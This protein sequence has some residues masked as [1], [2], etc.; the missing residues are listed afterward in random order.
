MNAKNVLTGKLI[1]KTWHLLPT[2]CYATIFEISPSPSP[3][4]LRACVAALQSCAH[5]R[6]LYKGKEIHSWMLINGLVDSPFSVTSLINMYSKC[7]QLDDALIIFN[8]THDR[9]VYTWNAMMA[10]FIANGLSRNA[11]ELYQRMR[12]DGVVVPDK[13]TFPSAIKACSDLLEVLEVRKIHAGL[14]KFGLENDAFVSSALINFYLKIYLVE[15]AQL[16]FEE[17]PERDV[18]LWNAMINGYAQIGQFIMALQVFGMM[19]KENVV[20]SK[21]TVTGILSVLTMTGDLDNGRAVHGF[22]KKMGYESDIAVSNSLIDMYG[23]CKDVVDALEIFE[24]MLDRDIFSWNSIIAVHQQSGDHDGT[25]SL[26][27]RMREAGVCPDVVTITTVLPACSS[28]A[29]LMRGKEIHGYTIVSGMR[30]DEDGEEIHDIHAD[31]AILDM[32]AKCG[33]LKDAGLFFDK[34]R[35]KDVASWNIMIMGYGMHGFGNE[36]LI[37]F[38]LMCESGVRPDE[39]SFV[40]VLSACSH[41]GLV[42][43]G[44]QFLARMELDHGVI[45]TVEHYAC[46]VDMLGRAGRL[47]E[48]YKLAVTM[49]IESNPVVWRAF[50][51]ACRIHGNTTLAEIA[52]KRLLEIEPEH[53]GS[54]VLISNVYGSMGRYEDVSDVRHTMRQRNVKKTPGCSWIELKFGVHVFVTGDRMHPESDRIHAE[55]DALTGCLREYGYVPEVSYVQGCASL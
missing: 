3:C 31:N 18:V 14:F 2:L 1:K 12:L 4:D 51:A 9:N 16:L 22:A 43:L 36:A 15:E 29:A 44:W 19:R 34:M 40:G 7:S 49:P 5:H 39:V 25:L 20:P 11:F 27:D 48:A 55:L 52:N 8:A 47:D 42:S 37:M 23:K 32:Y 24:K 21:F 46:V 26:F 50:L 53:S 30:K 41:A 10:G 13:V 17:L 28:M 45:P 33:S 54:Y 6:N 38:R 35:N